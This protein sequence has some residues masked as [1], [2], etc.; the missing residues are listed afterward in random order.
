MPR[1]N[2]DLYVRGQVLDAYRALDD[3]LF[4]PKAFEGS[5]LRKTQTIIYNQEIRRKQQIQQEL[6]DYY[7]IGQLWNEEVEHIWDPRER[8]TVL[9]GLAQILPRREAFAAERIYQLFQYKPEALPR[10][11]GITKTNISDLTPRAFE[12]LQQEVHMFQRDFDVV[13]H[14][15]D[16]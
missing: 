9:R 4:E 7:R 10:L 6:Q 5:V 3:P 16:V 11:T 13:E 8:K 2:N 15:L 14:F 1:F 12:E